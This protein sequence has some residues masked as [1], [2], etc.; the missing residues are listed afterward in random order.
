MSTAGE[1]DEP[2]DALET[3]LGV[4]AWAGGG[5]R[6]FGLSWVGDDARVHAE[7]FDAI[8]LELAVLWP[9]VAIPER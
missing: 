3:G 8:E 2:S 7:P 6:L 9:H 5:R 1:S 4:L